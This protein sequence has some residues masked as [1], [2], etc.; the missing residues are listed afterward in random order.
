MAATTTSNPSSVADRLQTYFSKR[1]LEVQVDELRL[2]QFAKQEDLPAK[3]SARTIR[4]F[5]PAKAGG[6]SGQ[7]SATPGLYASPTTT[8]VVHALTEGT[9]IS[10]FRENDWTK[11]DATLKQYGAATKI[12]DIVSM[13]D[14]YQPLKQNIELMGRDSALSYDTVIRNAI[15]GSTHPDGATTPLT[16]GSDGT[17]GCELFVATSTTIKN[18][19]VSATNF[20]TLLALTQTQGIATRLFVLAAATR[21]RTNK[22]PK[23][24]AGR[25]VCVLPPAVQH[26]LVRD[27]DY[28]NAFQ[29]RGNAGVYKGMI[30]EIDGFIFIEATNPF[31]EDETYGTFDSADAVGTAGLIFSTLFLGSGAYG[32]PKLAGTKSP[33]RPQFFINDKPDKTDPLNQY[34]VAGWKA[35]YMAMG[36]DSA[37]IVVGR[38]K[39]TFI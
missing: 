32:A 21:L 28:K 31:I 12:S 2:D 16:H 29:G 15:Q 9:A 38:S 26:D 39:S 8:D 34:V 36:L 10:N 13:I 33:L 35:Y 19:G 17:N 30:G 3:A 18:S 5:K 14:A 24:K 27:S 1:L 25:Y 20:A 23:L 22:A 37:N 7:F 6:G 11:V 4:F